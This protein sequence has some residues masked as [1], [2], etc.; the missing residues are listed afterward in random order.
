MNENE[1]AMYLTDKLRLMSAYNNGT[2][3]SPQAK[4]MAEYLIRSGGKLPADM[5][6]LANPSNLGTLGKQ[7]LNITKGATSFTPAQQAVLNGALG[8]GRAIQFLQNPYT[9]AVAN[10]IGMYN[11]EK[12]RQAEL[13]ARMSK[14]IP[15]QATFDAYYSNAP[16]QTRGRLGFIFPEYYQDYMRRH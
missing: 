10:S 6:S 15:D 1:I 14:T 8:T 5:T 3:Q 7:A 9:I 4:Q 2:L 13:E 11:Q 16:T 12:A